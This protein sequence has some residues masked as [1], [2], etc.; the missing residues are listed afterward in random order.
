MEG[1]VA[2]HPTKKL[3]L[4]IVG[5]NLLHDHHL[6]YVISGNNPR[7]EIQRSVYGKAAIRW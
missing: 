3:E 2:W 5:Q 7:E 6:E 4:S 1:R